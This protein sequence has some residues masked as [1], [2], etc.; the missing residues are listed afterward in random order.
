M[1]PELPRLS[2]ADAFGALENVQTLAF[3]TTTE[4]GGKILTDGAA[5][6]LIAAYG[7]DLPATV[8]QLD[9][10]GETGQIRTMALPPLAGD[11]RWAHLPATLMFVGIGSP[12]DSPAEES[13]TS[14]AR[15]AGGA[16]ARAL[17]PG[18][19]AAVAGFDDRG[20]QVA[21]AFG[22]GIHLAA[23][24]HPATG[25]LE[26]PDP[27]R[28]VRL[29]G[30]SEEAVT[31]AVDRA[32]ATVAARTWAATPSNTKN[33]EWLAGEARREGKNARA[34]V[35]VYDEK[36]IDAQGMG[37]LAAVGGGSASPPRFVVVEYTPKGRPPGE[38]VVVGKGITYDTGGLDIKPR[39]AMMPMKTDMTGAAVTLAAVI[40][41]AKARAENS[42]AAVLPL[43]ENAVSGSSYRPS[44]VVTMFDGTTVEIGNTDAEGRMVLADAMAWAREE[45]SPK[46]LID[47]ATLT[48]AATL[49]LGK[50]HGALYATTT[51]LAGAFLAAGA[52]T[53]EPVWRMPLVA[54]YRASLDSPVADLS[55]ISGPG[56]GAGSITAALFLQHFAGDT[57]WVHLDIAG[58]A[59]AAKTGGLVTE[60][61][62]GFSA[63]L[64]R[65]YL[66]NDP[67]AAL[68][69]D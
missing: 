53:G 60:G 28:S 44:D 41:A 17:R 26:R 30:A 29:V 45:Y 52:A 64:L 1:K 22:E 4:G 47:V 46:L 38:I 34:T 14:R 42:I 59:R 61:A 35:R 49:G 18:V 20:E 31:A 2:A 37:G 55:H 24:R 5:A 9:I 51:P 7:V 27:P 67:L 62:T 43:A 50:I 19:A 69:E 48:G 56:V 32:H 23:Y 16:F 65:H 36:W 39:E 66:L 54:E 12:E 25:T 63:R 57:P 13:A 40:G 21:T 68:E 33:P 6:D 58:P 10:T 15:R 3:L 11:D 8:R